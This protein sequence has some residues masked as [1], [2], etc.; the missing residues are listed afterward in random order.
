[1]N[2]IDPVNHNANF[3]IALASERHFGQRYG[4]KAARLLLDYGFALEVFPFNPRALHLYETLGFRQEGRHREILHQDGTYHDA[5]VMSLLRRV[6]AGQIYGRP[7]NQRDGILA[8]LP[9]PFPRDA[10]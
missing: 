4:T 6:Q 9:G 10:P 1:M 3:R 2:D 7:R 5:I 8:P